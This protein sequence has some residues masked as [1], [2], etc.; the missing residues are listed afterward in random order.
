VDIESIKVSIIVPTFQRADFL[1]VTLNSVLNQSYKDWECII[2]D[3]DEN[4]SARNIVRKFIE[5]DDRFFYFGRPV[6]FEKGVSACRNLG[7]SKSS[8]RYIQYLDDDDLLSTHKIKKQ[9]EVLTEI[10]DSFALAT[11]DWDLLWKDKKFE[12]IRLIAKDYIT[13][14]EYFPILS[15]NYSFFPL[16]T[17][18]TS[19]DLIEKAGLWDTS[20]L[21]NED[22]EF[23]T[24]VIVNSTI[25]FHVEGCHVYYRSHDVNRISLKNSSE[26]TKS[27]IDSYKKIFVNQ[28]AFGLL[29]IPYFKWKLYK[30]VLQNWKRDKLV[31][32]AERKFLKSVGIDLNYIHLFSFKFKMYKLIKSLKIN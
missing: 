18:L 22:A 30:L 24:R 14:E 19:R 3:D 2:V 21:I 25:L 9:V 16:H 27:L 20:L 8:G 23:F 29:Y 6:Q 15:E 31:F 5:K 7:F 10:R 13:P 1:E 4:Q 17:F 32:F 28:K 11:C 26:V 12:P